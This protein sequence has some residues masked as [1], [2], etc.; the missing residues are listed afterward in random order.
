[1]VRRE[2]ERERQGGNGG[3]PWLE[4][5]SSEGRLLSA[6]E[7]D[8]GRAAA[9]RRERELG[10]AACAAE[11]VIWGAGE[12]ESERELGIGNGLHA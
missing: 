9:R 10:R 6:E 5:A 7:G 12:A 3:S 2:R 8:C 4:R 1:M 11:K